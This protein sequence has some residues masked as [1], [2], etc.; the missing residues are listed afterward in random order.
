MIIEKYI[1]DLLYRYQCVTVPNFGAFIAENI[2]A[3][4]K[5]SASTFLPPQKGISFNTNIKNNDGLLAN[6]IATNEKI[7]YEKA[8]HKIANQVAIWNG[9]LIALETIELKNIGNFH[10]NGESNIVFEPT[11]TVNFLTSAFGLSAFIQPE[12]KRE[13]YKKQ[14]EALEEKVPIVFTLEKKKNYNFVKYAAVITLFLAGGLFGGKAYYDNQIETQTLLVQKEVQEKVQEQI[15]Q[16]TF[17]IDAPVNT[18]EL[19]V[20]EEKLP[21]HLIAAAFRSE[22]NA[23]KALQMLK[24]QG[25]KAVKL[26]KNKYDLIPVAYGSFKTLEEAHGVKSKLHQE[27]QIQAWL[28]I[29]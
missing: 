25:Y 6:H 15:Q 16:A 24:E 2:S 26:E 12:I 18:L 21:Y 28:L 11:N 7:S 8:M 23:E 17:F 3:Q 13:A 14:V 5:G 19:P 10:L 4:V 1:T 29:E 20:K 9:K 27:E 22:E